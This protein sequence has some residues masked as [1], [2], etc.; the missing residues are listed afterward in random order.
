M[1]NSR[2]RGRDRY[3]VKKEQKS[4]IIKKERKKEGEREMKGERK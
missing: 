4:D 2:E 1:K 3:R